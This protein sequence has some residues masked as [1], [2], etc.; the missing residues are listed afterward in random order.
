[1]TI[2]A[3]TDSVSPTSSKAKQT[4]DGI[5]QLYPDDV[6]VIFKDYPSLI[7]EAR[8]FGVV[9]AP[10]FFIN[11]HKLVGARSLEDFKLAVSAALGIA[12]PV[13]IRPPFQEQHQNFPA[14]I[15]EVNTVGAASQGPDDAPVV[16][17]EF[18]DFQCPF[19]ARATQTMQE[20]MKRYPKQVRWVF[21]HF[22]LDFHPD[23]K[24]AHAAAMA[25]G[26][27]GK[28]W[29]MHDL[30]FLRQN[31][32]KREHLIKYA[33]ELGLDI[34]RFRASLD[35]EEYQ[36][37][38]DQ[39]VSEGKRLDVS[40]TPTFFVNGK[41]MVGAKPIEDFVSIVESEIAASAN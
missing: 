24:L 3:Y 32:I 39:D 10:T 30:L 29:E 23:A 34:D 13:E 38:M 40:G 5:M 37:Q 36:M 18:S 12:Q 17:V 33:E 41:R 25:A 7:E 8:G 11:G 9:T 21:K 28:F 1:V 31:A 2:I 15:V 35:S 19:C 4:L 16:I 6:R 27:H 22:P 20:I 26:A 14:S